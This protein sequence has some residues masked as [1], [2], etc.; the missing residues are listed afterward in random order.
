MSNGRPTAKTRGQRKAAET[1]LGFSWGL[2]N[3]LTLGLG[4][5]LLA[6]GYVALSRGSVTL[7]PVLLVFGYCVVVPAS[8]L[9]PGR[10][11]GSGE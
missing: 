7:A 5:G 9:L 6:A 2:W 10:S 4:V 1:D 11:R 8:L 3:S